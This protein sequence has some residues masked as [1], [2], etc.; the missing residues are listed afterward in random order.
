MQETHDPINRAPSQEDAGLLADPRDAEAFAA[1]RVLDDATLRSDLRT[2]GLARSR[3]FRWEQCAR[4][5]LD[6]YREL[7]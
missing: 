6:V 7:L 2:R 3:L 4:M 1:A 5:T